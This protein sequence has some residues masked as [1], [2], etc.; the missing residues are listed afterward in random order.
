MQN[1]EDALRIRL[2]NAQYTEA[3]L[4]NSAEFSRW[5]EVQADCQF[6]NRELNRVMNALFPVPQLKSKSL[7]GIV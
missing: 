2:E 3:D 5:S 6:N 1:I 4:P 7:G